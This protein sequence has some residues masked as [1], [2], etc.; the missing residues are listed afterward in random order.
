MAVDR[1]ERDF[2]LHR[3]VGERQNLK[4]DRRPPPLGE[5][6]DALHAT[7][8]GVH[9]DNDGGERGHVPNAQTRLPGASSPVGSSCAL[10]AP[11]TPSC[12]GVSWSESQ[13]RFSLPMPCSAATVPPS[14]T[15]WRSVDSTTCS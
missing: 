10:M 12:S 13:R 8:R 3:L 5:E 9:V 7:E 6:I 4:T 1:L 15:T 11:I 14:A 2:A